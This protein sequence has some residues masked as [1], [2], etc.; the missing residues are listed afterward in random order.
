MTAHELVLRLPK[1]VLHDHLDGGLR[2]ATL[3]EL[4]AQIGHTLPA[5]T[6]EKLGE[7]FVDAA[8]SGSLVRYLE[9]FEHTVAVMQTVEGL[10]RVAREAVEDH[11]ADGV[12]YAEL[13]WAPEQHQN[14]GLSLQEAVDAVREGIAQ[15]VAAVAEHGKT[16]VVHQL[17]TAMRHADRWEEIADL[18]LANRDA[19]VCGFDIAGAEDGFLPDR[20]PQV[21]RTL[22]DAGMPVTIHAGEAAGL[23]SIS[24]AVHL[25]QALRI[26]HGVRIVDDIAGFD[27]DQPQLGRLAHWV[28]DNQI[29]L[30]V[31]PC[32]NIQTGAAPSVADHPI[33]GLRDLDFAVTINTDNRLMS[34][35][36]MTNEMTRLV[37]E[38][39]WSLDDLR[40]AT[41]AAAWSAFIHHDERH[42]LGE[43]IIAAYDQLTN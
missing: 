42:A 2:P 23:E 40:D 38:A 21:W 26:G 15:G 8:D 16:I 4:A 29:A 41:L 20:F 5:D 13:R 17:I 34:G 10:T 7:W 25:G 1:V 36:S 43:R 37:N 28:R 35:T 19:G 24:Q 32:S 22:N 30:E 14:S 3:I 6:P 18:A 31:C 12:V 39:G 33:S 27:T 9:T 11:A